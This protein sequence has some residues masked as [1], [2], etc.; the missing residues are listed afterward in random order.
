[1]PVWPSSVIV[2]VELPLAIGLVPPVTEPPTV[3][4]LTVTVVAVEFAASQTPLLT[5]ALNWV[6]AVNTPEVYVATVFVISVHDVPS[7]DDC[8]LVIVQL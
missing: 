3:K 5:T 8:H 4:G 2:P 1:M 7:V 6:V